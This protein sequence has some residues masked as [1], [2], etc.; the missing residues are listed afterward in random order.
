MAVR[1]KICGVTSEAD[2]EQAALLG[3]DAVGLNFFA[4]SPRCVDHTR[5]EAILRRLPP[6]VE[7]VGLFVEQPLREVFEVVNRFARIRTIQWHGERRELCDAYPF[8]F[9]PAF[10]VRDRQSLVTITRYLDM[11]RGLNCLPAAVLVDAH[12][13]GQYGGTGQVAPWEL[14][15]DF[16]PGVPVILAGGLTPDNVAEAVRIVRPYGVD[17][18]SGVEARPGV[19]DVEKLRR[20]IANARAAAP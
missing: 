18:A 14:L 8:Q 6:F 11:A 7:P 10:P 13:P 2:A 4:K 16:R 5:A 17:V 1:I 3:A 20:F 9:I 15:A 19:K 12:V